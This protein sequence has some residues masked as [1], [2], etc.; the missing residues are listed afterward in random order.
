LLRRGRLHQPE[1]RSR[2]KNR[3]TR[4][5]RDVS[6]RQCA[7]AAPRLGGATDVVGQV[8]AVWSV[9]QDRSTPLTSLSGP[10]QSRWAIQRALPLLSQSPSNLRG[11]GDQCSIGNRANHQPFAAAGHRLCPEQTILPPAQ[12]SG[13][14]KASC[15]HRRA[16]RR[17]A[18]DLGDARR[19]GAAAQHQAV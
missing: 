5:A 3:S 4:R 15:G 17:R 13:S 1:S 18:I 16:G 9:I 12:S 8:R 7:Q 6:P 2:P 10:R 19:G 11:A 14:V